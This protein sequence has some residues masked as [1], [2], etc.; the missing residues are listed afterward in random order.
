V[1][2][3]TL[4]IVDDIGAILVIAIFYS[5]GLDAAWLLGGVAVVV[6]LLCMRRFGSVTPWVYAIPGVALWVCTH[7][8]GVHAT[9]A[10]VVLALLIP[11]TRGPERGPLER[12]ED[13]LHPWSSFLVVP[14]F[15]LASAG[16]ALGSTTL[17]AA[18]TSAIAGGIVLG[19]VLGKPL[20]IVGA[21]LLALRSGRV[22]LPAGMR[23]PHVVGVGLVAGMGFTVSLFIANLSFVHLRLDVAKIAILAAS[24]VAA[25][26]G[27]LVFITNHARQRGAEKDHAA[28]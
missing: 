8:S 17:D 18:S 11:A 24:L 15:A 22:E 6:V 12:I 5:E 27:A 10:G 23:V 9:I 4:A 25:T 26:F 16:V 20:G 3:L 7:E 1:F 2:L 19:L 13:A 28:G 14:L 21:T